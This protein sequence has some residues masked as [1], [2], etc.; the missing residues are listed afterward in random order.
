MV[1]RWRNSIPSLIRI[2]FAI[3]P[4]LDLIICHVAASVTVVLNFS[5]C[6][7]RLVLISKFL[8][9]LDRTNTFSV[10][11]RFNLKKIMLSLMQL[12][13]LVLV[14]I[15]RPVENTRDMPVNTAVLCIVLK[16]IR[17]F[18]LFLRNLS[19]FNY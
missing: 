2:C 9:F 10:M 15:C 11:T 16:S 19:I 7:L 1:H 6:Y 12:R 14:R 5:N 4:S 3:L 13:F 8:G 17:T 18:K